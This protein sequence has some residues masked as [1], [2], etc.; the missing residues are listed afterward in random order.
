MVDPLDSRGPSHIS[1]TLDT[2]AERLTSWHWSSIARWQYASGCPP[3]PRDQPG[4]GSGGR[5]TAH[6]ASVMSEGYCRIRSGRSAVF[7][8]PAELNSS[9]ASTYN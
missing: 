8:N 2:A 4:T 3:R 6:S 1:P 5:T 7:P 9:G